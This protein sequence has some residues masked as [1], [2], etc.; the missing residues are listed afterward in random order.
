MN[1]QPVQVYSPNRRWRGV[2]CDTIDRLSS[3]SE[4]RLCHKQSRAA[5]VNAFHR[6]RE[7]S[8]NGGSTTPS[9]FTDLIHVLV[10]IGLPAGSVNSALSR[11]AIDASPDGV[12]VNVFNDLASLPRY[13]DVLETV[14]KR[15]AVVNL[16]FG[17]C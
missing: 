11:H 4:D 9:A 1:P 2:V 17:R 3:R 5:L 10:L 13:R 12:M 6:V 15:D 16:R 7:G 14:A 8:N